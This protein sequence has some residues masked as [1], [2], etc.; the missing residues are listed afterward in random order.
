LKR[1]RIT[2]QAK[3]KARM[4]LKERERLPKSRKFGLNKSQANKLG[5][6]SGVERAKQIIR[7]KSLPIKDAKR[8]AS[9]YQRFKNCKTPKCEG[10]INLW[11]GRSFG[12]RAVSFVKKN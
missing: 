10:A 12:R 3:Q 4:A 11:G 9:F 6:N 1:L 8:V 5:I 7:S 2:N